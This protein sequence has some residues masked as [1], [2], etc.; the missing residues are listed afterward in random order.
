MVA[1]LAQLQLSNLTT[2]FLD[3]TGVT[4]AAVFEL[5]RQTG[6]S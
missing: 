6:Q 1:E 3:Q 2:I 4:A 5:A